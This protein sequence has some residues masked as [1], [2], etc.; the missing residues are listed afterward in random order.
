MLVE[1]RGG[2]AWQD[3]WEEGSGGCVPDAERYVSYFDTYKCVF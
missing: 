2:Y 1:S 3:I